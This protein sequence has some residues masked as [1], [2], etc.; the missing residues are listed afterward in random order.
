[1]EIIKKDLN[2]QTNIASKYDR[3]LA[4]YNLDIT[5][6][7]VKSAVKKIIVERVAENDTLEVKKFLLS[8]LEQ[9][10]L[11]KAFSR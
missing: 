10:I 5:D 4:E 2:R 11:R 1:M 3:I 7:E 9:S 8:C 6:E